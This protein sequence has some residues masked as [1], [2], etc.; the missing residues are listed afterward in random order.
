MGRKENKM[1]KKLTTEGFIQRAKQIHGDEYEYDEVEY[2]NSKT[3]VKIRCKKHGI[4]EQTPTIHINFECGCPKCYK[5]ETFTTEI[6]IEKAKSIHGDKYD[7]SLSNYINANTL[8]K[9]ICKNHGIFEQK[10]VNHYCSNCPE[11]GGKRRL[12]TE[13]FIKKSK[14]IYGDKYDFSKSI[15]NNNTD[16][17][18]IICPKHGSFFKRPKCFFKGEACRKCLPKKPRLTV[19]IFKERSNKIHNNIYDYSLITKEN[20]P[21]SDGKVLIKCKYHGIFE[22][23]THSHSSGRGCPNCKVFI[24]RAETEWLDNLNIPK[25]WGQQIIYIN[26][27]KIKPDAYDAETKTIYEFYG[28]YWHGNPDVFPADKINTRTNGNKT[29]KELY[30]KTMEK[31]KIIKE[32]GYNLITMWE[33]DWKE[34]KKSNH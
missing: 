27:L 14:L 22:Q 6:F 13:L 12:T 32:A 25:E 30:D 7:Y 31:E 20:F 17:V 21:G 18:E 1:A 2:K 28:D 26:E 16:K 24:S 33:K 15:I 29:M 3:L 8:L 34:Y 11:C 4:F 9:I 10:P 5:T 23:N 19:E